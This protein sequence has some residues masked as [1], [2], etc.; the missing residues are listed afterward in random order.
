MHDLVQALI[1]AA[2]CPWYQAQ[3]MEETAALKRT[4]LDALLQE[5]DR[6]LPLLL[7]DLERHALTMI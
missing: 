6:L 3:V 4:F 2:D 5:R 7:A 1:P